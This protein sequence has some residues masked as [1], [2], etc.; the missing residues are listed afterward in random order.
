MDSSCIFFEIVEFGLEQPPH[1]AGTAQRTSSMRSTCLIEMGKQ[2]D[3]LER[4]RKERP[5]ATE[6]ANSKAAS[7]L[8]A[9]VTA[10][11]AR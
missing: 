7:T 9:R 4:G 10:T 11:L 3:Q 5:A 1:E 8:D 6:V 2:S